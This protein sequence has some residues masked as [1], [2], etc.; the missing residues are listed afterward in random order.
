MI[1]SYRPHHNPSSSLQVPL[2]ADADAALKK[3]LQQTDAQQTSQHRR[4]QLV[5]RQTPCATS[6]MSEKQPPTVVE[7][8]TTGDVEDE[9]PNTAAKS[10][11]D[12]KAA[13]ALASLEGGDDASG[14]KEDVDAEAAK[15]AL[16]NLGGAEG[17]AGAGEKK[18]NLPVRNVKVDAADVSLLVR[19]LPLSEVGGRCVGWQSPEFLGDLLADKT[20]C[21][22]T[23]SKS[24]SPR[25]RRCSRRTKETRSRRCEPSSRPERNIHTV[26]RPNASNVDHTRSRA[27]SC[28]DDDSTSPHP[29]PAHRLAARGTAEVPLSERQ[30]RHHHRWTG[31]AHGSW[32]HRP[33]VG[34]M[35]GAIIR[36]GHRLW[37]GL[38]PIWPESPAG[39]H[40]SSG[41]R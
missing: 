10:A 27:R 26:R 16:G 12:R 29:T 9:I 28:A 17:A 37:G 18:V 19:A 41:P 40:E 2:T 38:E 30:R 4:P 35:M 33:V 1:Q 25:P 8:A 7:G 21:R 36:P 13:S 32:G 23:S 3:A 31:S 34:A 6:I 15:K 24:P 20:T 14:A 11:E 22:S 5:D 39:V